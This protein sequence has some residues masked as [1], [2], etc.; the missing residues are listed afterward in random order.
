M[1]FYSQM[2][3]EAGYFTL[4]DVAEGLT[5][6][7]VRRH[8]HVFGEAAAANAADVQRTWDEVKAEEK[9]SAGLASRGLLEDVSR[10]MPALIEASKLGSRAARVGFDWPMRVG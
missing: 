6:K 10:A 5:S 3:S 7:L 1:L 2:A 4:A 9:A 8:P